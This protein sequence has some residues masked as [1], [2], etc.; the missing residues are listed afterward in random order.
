MNFNVGDKVFHHGHG[1]GTIIALNGN[2]QNADQLL[3]ELCK[4]D[5][6]ELA[7]LTVSGFYSADKY[8]YQVQFDSGYS[9]VYCDLSLKPLN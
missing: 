5:V 6:M 9:D 1:S 4:Y 8:P 7:P 2:N 3:D